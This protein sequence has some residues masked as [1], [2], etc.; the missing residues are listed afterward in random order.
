MTVRVREIIDAQS[1]S[2][3]IWLFMSSVVV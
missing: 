3:V 2:S 1:P